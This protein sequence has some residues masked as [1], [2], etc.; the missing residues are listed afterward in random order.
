MNTENR[1]AVITGSSRG[2]G[3][4][5]ALLFAK[6]GYNVLI[7]FFSHEHAANKVKELIELEGRR[8]IIVKANISNREEI[9]ILFKSAFDTFSRIDVLINNAGILHQKPFETITDDDFDKTLDVCLKGPF[10]CTQEILPYFKKQESGRIINI[11]SMGGQF[12]GPKAPHYSAAKAGLICF[13]K[14]SA[15][16][17]APYRVT[18]NCISP[19]FI[20]TDMSK[21][22]IKSMGG[23]EMAGKI[24][25][26][27]RIGKPEDIA[28][29]ALY[30]ASNEASFVT[31]QTINVNGGQYML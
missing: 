12:G 10:I 31:G 8:A 30:L 11:A 26:V 2:I 29:A 9:K 17:M 22:E 1:V 3:R 23:K 6:N 24:I 27:K 21:A 7:N 19:G 14:S 15:R 4:G 25:P 16:I 18:V 5:I 28:A 20:D 13:T